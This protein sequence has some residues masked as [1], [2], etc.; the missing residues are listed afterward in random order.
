[1]D[2]D[3]VL[4]VVVL[5]DESLDTLFGDTQAPADGMGNA[6]EGKIM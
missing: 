1:M 6:D 5:V 3:M 2:D 4:E